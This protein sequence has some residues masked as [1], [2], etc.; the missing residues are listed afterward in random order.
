MEFKTKGI[1]ELEYKIESFREFLSNT[2]GRLENLWRNSSGKP[3]ED[4]ERRAHD[5][6]RIILNLFNMRFPQQTTNE[7]TELPKDEHQSNT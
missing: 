6:A 7:Q 4:E 2:V 1:I 5:L 3:W